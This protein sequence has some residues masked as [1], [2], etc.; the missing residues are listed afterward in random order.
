VTSPATCYTPLVGAELKLGADAAATVPLRPGFQYA[1]LALDGAPV[2]E[3]VTVKPGPLLYAGSGRSS[4]RLAA[5]AP[6]RL[7]LLGG[8]PFD[9]RLVM[10]WNFVG[11]EHDEIVAMRADWE[12]QTPRFGEVRGYDGPRLPAPPMPLTRLVP[13]SPGPPVRFGPGPA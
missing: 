2:V 13:R 12:S 6:A 10:W 7:L 4:L 3:Q 9:E 8:E 11:R 5:A 1:V